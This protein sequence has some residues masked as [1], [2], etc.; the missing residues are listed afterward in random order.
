MSGWDGVAGRCIYPRSRVCPR[1]GQ[2]RSGYRSAA[3]NAPRPSPQDDDGHRLAPV[4][5]RQSRS[6]DGREGRLP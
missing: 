5:N 6:G 4:G 3:I 2:N 1:R